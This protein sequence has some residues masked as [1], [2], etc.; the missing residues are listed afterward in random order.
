MFRDRR[1]FEAGINHYVPAM[2]YAN[3]IDHSQPQQFNLGSPAANA[4]IQASIAANAAIGTVVNI[5]NYTLSERYGRTLIFTPSGDPGASGGQIDWKGFDYLGQPMVQRVSGVNGSSTAIAGNKA[6]KRIMSATIVT[7][8]TNPVTWSV[9]TGDSLGL[10][11]R[12][13]VIWAREN[14]VLVTVAA[15]FTAGV[16]TDPATATT[17]DPRGLYNPT[18]AFNG[19][20]E[21]LVSILGDDAVNASNNGG[22][23]GIRHYYA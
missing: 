8:S 19:A 22:L 23:H 4:V 14:G 12:G 21:I 17:G 5:T 16:T 20:T 3:S 1:Q 10:P 2:Q 7:A 15:Q 18:A 11:Y 9:S 6:F 13:D